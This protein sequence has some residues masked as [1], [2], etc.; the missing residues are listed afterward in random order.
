[1]YTSGDFRSQ[2][3]RSAC[4]S[5]KR[6]SAQSQE[7]LKESPDDPAANLAVGSYLCFNKDQWERGLPMLAKGSDPALYW[8]ILRLFCVLIAAVGLLCGPVPLW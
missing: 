8:L 3:R 6:K 5:G 2:G 7:K 4:H 1:M